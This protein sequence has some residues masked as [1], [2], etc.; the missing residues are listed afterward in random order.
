MKLINNGYLFNFSF[1]LIA[2]IFFKLNFTITVTVNGTVS[3]FILYLL[4][5]VEEK[6]YRVRY[7]S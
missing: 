3:I 6:S 1:G 7:K 4:K 2:N 5:D